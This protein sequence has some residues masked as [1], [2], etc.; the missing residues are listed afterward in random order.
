VSKL[1]GTKIKYSNFDLNLVAWLGTDISGLAEK[2]SAT[3]KVT[4]ILKI[5][6]KY[7]AILF[8]KVVP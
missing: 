8:D 4:N 7:T 5:Y 1:K 2:T 6:Q 3:V